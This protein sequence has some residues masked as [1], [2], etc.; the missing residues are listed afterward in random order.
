MNA[1]PTVNKETEPQNTQNTQMDIG[2]DRINTKGTLTRTD[3][4]SR[5]AGRRPGIHVFHA[6]KDMDAAVRP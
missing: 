5:H 1:V 6:A 4:G 2:E 3:G